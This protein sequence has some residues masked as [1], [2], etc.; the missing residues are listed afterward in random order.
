MLCSRCQKNEASVFVKEL[1][2]NQI[3]EAQYCLSCAKPVESVPGLPPVFA[4]LSTMAGGKAHS[5]RVA[6]C[7]TCGLRFSDFKKS[8]RLGCADCYQSFERPLTDLLKRIHGASEHCGKAPTDEPGKLRKKE[9]A[10]LKK[11]LS[12]AVEKESFEAAARLRDR[13]RKLEKEAS[14]S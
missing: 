12:E 3:S 9:L 5:P 1:V 10:R 14:C 11:E 2:N 6:P 4:W 13:I 8:G 7:R